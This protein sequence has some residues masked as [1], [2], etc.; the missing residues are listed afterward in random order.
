MQMLATGDLG[1]NE[2]F[3]RFETNDA[4]RPDA[5]GRFLQQVERIAHL[6]RHFGPEAEV[7]LVEIG[8]GSVWGKI[9][10]AIGAIGGIAGFGSFVLDLEARMHSDTDPLAQAIAAMS[11]DSSVVSATIVTKERV[12]VVRTADMP[13]VET[14][15]TARNRVPDRL[16]SSDQGRVV[17]L[18]LHGR[19]PGFYPKDAIDERSETRYLV[20]ELH[21]A[22]PGSGMPFVTDEGRRYELTNTNEIE[23]LGGFPFGKRVILEARA[24]ATGWQHGQIEPVDVYEIA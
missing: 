10:V 11:L 7:R 14:V 13:A 12:I 15:K 2:F 5:L 21:P 18:P 19:V 20:G 8:T 6:R 23:Y 4:L 17:E 24:T 9:T 3:F 1:P 16:T 22:N